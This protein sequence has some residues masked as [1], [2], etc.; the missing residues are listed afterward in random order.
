M[1]IMLIL[2][3]AE[4]LRINSSHDEVPNRKMLRFSVL[5]LTTVAA[6]T[7]MGHK[8]TLYD[9]NVEPVDLWADADV[10]GISF[11]TGLANRAYELA[12]HFK[13]RGIITVAGGFH[14]T[15]CTQEAMQH[16]DIV[17][18]GQAEGIW[19]QVLNDI[20]NKRYKKLYENRNA[21]DLADV[22]IP[23]RSLLDYKK[24]HY[25]TTYA[26]QV[27]R[28]CQHKCRFCSVT[29]FFNH[30]YQTRPI[31]NVLA[32]LGD[33][34]KHFMFV[35]DNIIADVEYAK[36]LFAAMIPMKKRWI[37]QCSIEIAED[38]ELL[39]LAYK[40][41]CRGLFVGIETTSKANLENMDKAFNQ[42]DSTGSPQAD[43]YIRKIAIIRK[44]G[45]GV[46][47]GMIVGM[48]NDDAAV[49]ERT[50]KFLDKAKIDALQLAILTPQPGTPL[51]DEFEKAGR[52]IDN[53]WSHYDYRHVVIEPKLMTSHQLQNG[54]DWLYNKFYGLHKIIFRTVRALFKF[55]PLTAYLV[56]RLNMNYRY[57]NLREG[58]VGFNPARDVKPRINSNKRFIFNMPTA[59]IF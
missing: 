53:D 11:M 59:K 4:H 8:V 10:V 45:I 52:I 24:E 31:E 32:E 44:R 5:G 21:A 2:P 40:A 38:K 18:A 13:S 19:P 9:E 23:R 42:S 50:L 17:V 36:K 54:A 56:Y 20:Q 48:D 37:S 28:G 58:I 3:A 43:D 14:P 39:D 15:L 29:A 47:A 34:P 26:V 55:G 1:K 22:P 51:R 46:Q 7:P 25:A 16:F 12:A 49:F 30:N 41:G 33:V 6:L 27:G 57:D 35:D